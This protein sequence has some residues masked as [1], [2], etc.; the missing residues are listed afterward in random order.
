MEIK[1]DSDFERVMNELQTNF[2][3]S[4]IEVLPDGFKDLLN[5]TIKAV[6][7]CSIHNVSG[8]LPTDTE[9]QE[10]AKKEAAKWEKD[11]A[12]AVAYASNLIDGALLMRSRLLSNDR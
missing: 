2:G 8:S 9:I 4:N 7:N 1:Y 3:W 5:D 11:K 6:K 12:K 10:W